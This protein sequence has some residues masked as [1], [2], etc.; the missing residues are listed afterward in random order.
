M[1]TECGCRVFSFS[2]QIFSHTV[3]SDYYF[4]VCLVY[5]G[6]H[7]CV[8]AH[9][10][11]YLFMCAHIEARDQDQV[12]PRVCSILVFETGSPAV[13]VRLTRKYAP[14]ICLSLPPQCWGYECS[15]D[16]MP[17]SL[18]WVLRIQTLFFMIVQHTLYPLIHLLI[19]R[20]IFKIL[21]V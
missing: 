1:C 14:G 10:W 16:P 20:N 8:C 17:D 9:V 18:R 3:F 11:M 12:F 13:L 15:Q 21:C 7:M 5:V 4:C 19:P 6:V 2:V